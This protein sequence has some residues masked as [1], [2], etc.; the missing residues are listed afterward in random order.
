[1]Y[2]N[3]FQQLIKNCSNNYKDMEFASKPYMAKNKLV[4]K[5]Q[6]PPQDVNEEVPATEEEG[7]QPRTGAPEAPSEEPQVGYISV[8]VYTALGALPVP[9][10]V[11]TIYTIDESGEENA[12]YHYV[13]DENGRIPN[14]ALPSFYNPSNPLE[15]PKYYFTTYNMR[16]QAINYYTVNVLD[17]RVFPGVT[18][19]YRIDLIPVMAGPETDHP[20][21][22]IIIPPSPIDKSND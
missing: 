5:S 15:S 14:V 9:N 2:N 10:A 18:T 8:G 20:E 11:V 17:L 4:K 6:I 1:M 22:T 16:V 21:R 12:L 19:V 13:T 3:Y 7:T